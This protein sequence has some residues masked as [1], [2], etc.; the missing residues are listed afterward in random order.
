MIKLLICE[1][2]MILLDG[3]ATAV[4]A[5][6]DI[7]VVGKIT[8]A[9]KIVDEIAKTGANALLTDVCTENGNNSLNYLSDV[10]KRYPSLKIV[11]MTG[12]PEISFVERAKQSGAD[13]FVYKNVSTEELANVIRSTYGGYNVFPAQ[14]RQDAVSDL[15][16]QELTVLRYFCQGLD[17]KEIADKMC[18]SESSV[19]THISNM[20]SKTGFNSISRL[21]IYVVSSGLI[22][23]GDQID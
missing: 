19:K 3:I 8:D 22:V 21:A 2:Q 18:L 12:L 17:R 4:S 14:S 6:P 15:T 5:Y 23:P 10:K 16:K 1:D 9:E 11:V 7:E 20:L 13:S